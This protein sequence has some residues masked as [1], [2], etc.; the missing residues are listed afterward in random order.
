MGLGEMLR[1]LIDPYG[2]AEDEDYDDVAAQESW[3]QGDEARQGRRLHAVDEKRHSLAETRERR[4]FFLITPAGF[5][6][7]QQIAHRLKADTPVI[8]DV[9]NCGDDLARR[10][11]DFCSGLTYALEASLEYVGKS[12]VLLAPPGVE[13]AGGT[14]GASPRFF[15]QV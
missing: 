6:D 2:G 7:A 3:P 10:L 13:L 4:S 14:A 1:A 9:G 5:D 12:V 8:M 15:N 11:L